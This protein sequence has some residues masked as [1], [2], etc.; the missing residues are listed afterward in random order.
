[1]ICTPCGVDAP[2]RNIKDLLLL[3]ICNVL[4]ID[5][6]SLYSPT[7]VVDASRYYMEHP[8]IH[9]SVQFLLCEQV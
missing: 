8:D 2:L 5:Y 9:I 4:V 1:M 7:L 3:D 6:I